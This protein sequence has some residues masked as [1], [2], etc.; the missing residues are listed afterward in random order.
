QQQGATDD[1][2]AIHHFPGITAGAIRRARVPARI[3]RKR[4]DNIDLMTFGGE[5]EPKISSE[6]P[7]AQQFG[8]IVDA[9]DEDARRDLWRARRHAWAGAHGPRVQPRQS[10]LLLPPKR[11]PAMALSRAV[12]TLSAPG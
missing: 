8:R 5:M 4:G 3:M 11:L 12:N 1:V 10:L 6:A 7:H 9:V 2:H